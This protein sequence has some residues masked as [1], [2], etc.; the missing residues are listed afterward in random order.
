MKVAII[1]SGPCAAQAAIRFND[2]GADVIVF[3]VHDWLVRFQTYFSASSHDDGG[4]A[5]ELLSQLEKT[6]IRFIKSNVKRIH[7]SR[8]TRSQLAPNGRSRLSDMFRVV[9][10]DAPSEGILKQVEENPEV[11]KK[12]GDDVLSSLHEPMES[13][14][15]VDIVVAC[16]D[17]LFEQPGLTPS[18]AFALN[19]NRVRPNFKS[20]DNL[21]F[22][23]DKTD[24]VLVVGG[25]AEVL[26]YVAHSSA[27]ITHV[28]IED[29][30]CQEHLWLQALALSDSQWNED[31]SNYQE[32][33][34]EW[35]ALEDYMR[36]KVPAPKEPQARIKNII[37]GSVVAI[38]SLIDRPG[39]FVTIEYGEDHE[40]STHAFDQ[41]VNA[42]N[43]RWRSD[44]F[45][46]L[47]LDLGIPQMVVTESEPGFYALGFGQ[48]FIWNAHTC[49]EELNEIEND[50][51][52][53][54]RPVGDS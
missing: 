44:A 19:E 30:E 33:L 6:Q 50:I 25:N 22:E 14:H 11:F 42:R 27:Q 45:I 12:L 54:F 46:G 53:W 16:F 28:N 4:L 39:T 37:G 36:A 40:I 5:Q 29:E 51:T 13:F 7:K 18:G 48:P 17:E 9:V 26:N 2:L 49:D 41:I 10:S 15:D 23:T 31:K 47:A 34:H 20:L 43:P 38:D 8:L 24:T 1:G 52:K 32:K 3:A 21:W 35:R